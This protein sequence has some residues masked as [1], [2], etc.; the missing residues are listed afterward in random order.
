MKAWQRGFLIGGVI[1]LFVALLLWAAHVMVANVIATEQHAEQR[2]IA[3]RAKSTRPL[4]KRP[5]FTRTQAYAFL[6]AAQ[7]AETISDPLQRCL[8]YPDPPG[9]HW[10]HAA[11]VAY[12]KYRYQPIITMVQVRRYIQDGH[13]AELDRLF[14]QALHE[15]FTRPGA[16]GR[17]NRIFEEDFD[18]A[19]FATRSL[20]N[21]WKRQSPKSAFAF[22][23]SGFA[24]TKAAFAARGS[25]YLSKTPQSNIDSMDRLTTLADA[26]LQKAISLNPKV[27]PAYKGMV[28]LGG[29]D[30]GKSYALSAAKRGLAVE[31]GNF[32]I[33]DMLMWLEQP[34]WYGSL[35]KMDRVASLAS[36]HAKQNPILK[37]LAV[38]KDFYRID[39]CDC[40]ASVELPAYTAV[41]EN[42]ATARELL[43]A[44]QSAFDAREAPMS[45]IY[46]SEAL[47][48]DANLHDARVNRMYDLVEF[49]YTK[50][51]V[52]EGN[53]LLAK[54]LDDESAVEARG[55]AY[56]VMSDL[57]HAERDFETA[58]NLAP[59]DMWAW[60]KLGSIYINQKRWDKAW[61]VANQ[62][63]QKDP[64]HLDGWVMQAF[65]EEHQPRPGLRA[66]TD[67]IASHFGKDPKLK[68]YIAHLETAAQARAGKR[69][70]D[71]TSKLA[72]KSSE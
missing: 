72:R 9:S 56:L 36:K 27:M 54:S 34:N 12:C 35:A 7:R 19:S 28:D 1:V 66:T 5:L 15:Q 11:V 10:D 29:F 59:D 68:G 52:E 49:D 43:D 32:G 41:L 8:A 51:A 24:Y 69:H 23:A 14:A 48:F 44:G 16:R 20:L 17:L 71:A 50:W 57:P 53:H 70:G 2:S 37:L 39:H 40:D 38:E 3:V 45:A 65:I 47:R 67:Y 25:D 4:P 62:F 58:T 26:D 64:K 22:A 42:A 46:F 30:M 61:G 13:A 6:D 55:W 31:P 63:V 18:D 21:A 33:Y 60:G